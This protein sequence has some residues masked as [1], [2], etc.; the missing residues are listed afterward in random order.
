MAEIVC[1]K[2]SAT[3]IESEKWN[4]LVSIVQPFFP[5]ALKNNTLLK[6]GGEK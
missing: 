4:P 2:S 3:K 1:F 5:K 6:I